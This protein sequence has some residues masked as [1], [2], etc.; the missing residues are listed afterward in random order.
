LELL[1]IPFVFALLALVV[2]SNMMRSFSLVGGLISLLATI[3]H[4]LNFDTSS[5]V[6]IFD[7]QVVNSIGLT[8]KLGYDG[9][10]LFMVLL[11]SLITFLILLANYNRELSANKSFTSLLFFMQFG[12][13][14]VFTAFDGVLFYIFWELT[15]IPVF[16]I[17]LWFGAPDRKKV[18]I[19]FFIY[20]FVGSLAM[21]LSIISIKAYAPSFSHADLMA[22]ELTSKAAYWIFGGFF[23]AFAI[24]IPLFPFHTWQ[25]KTYTVSPMA[26]TMLL[27][28]LMLKMALYGMIRWMIV[29]APE[30]LPEMTYPIIVLA[31]IGVVYAA[32]IAIKQNDIKTLFAFA[33]ISH[34]G[35]IAA[36]AILWSHDNWSAVFIQMANHSLVAVGLFLAADIIEQRL[37][38]RSLSHLGGI[39]KVA[40]KFAF[41]FGGI[42]LASISVPLSSGFIGEFM[43]LKGLFSYNALI[44]IIAGSTL[45]FGAAYTL[46]AYQ[47]S[48]YGPAT[49]HHFADLSWNEWLTFLILLIIIVVF[50]IYPQAIIDFVSPSIDQLLGSIK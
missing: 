15:L 11:T 41:M 36:G 35:L 31:V 30:A 45:V 7:P 34:V 27:S 39:A 46:R 47:L 21:L 9:M 48:M 2:P 33:S 10:S 3:A 42:V 16:L 26:G 6:S 50:G 12:L 13:I 40:P 44:G 24:K 38:N 25:P 14:G 29:L 8:C 4:V 37:G 49:K 28:A 18:L 43:L 32:L 17:A 20:T 22:V 19:K 23:I 5:F 1:L